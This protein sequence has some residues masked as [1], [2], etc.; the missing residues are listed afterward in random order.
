MGTSSSVR[1]K[2]PASSTCQG[3]RVVGNRTGRGFEGQLI[4]SVLE[5]TPQDPPQFFFL[6]A[7]IPKGI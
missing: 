4:L 3:D 2:S 6:Q 5:R 7:K 1:R